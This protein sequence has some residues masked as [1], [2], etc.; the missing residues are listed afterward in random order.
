MKTPYILRTIATKI[1]EA[2]GNAILV[3]G[4][5]RDMLMGGEVKDYDI[6][7]FGLPS[8]ERLLEILSAFGTVNEVGR[9]F[10]ILKLRTGEEEYD[11]SLPRKERKSGSGHRG[12]SVEVDGSMG[13]AEAARR[14][15][16]TVNAIGYDLLTHEIYDPYGGCYDIQY[17]RLRHIDDVSFMEDPLRVYR[18]VQ[19]AARLQFEV[20]EE[21]AGLCRRMVEEGMLAELPKERIYEEF[22]K[23]LLKAS[24]PSVG[25][26]LMRA[27]GITER[28]FPELHALIDVPQ[29]PKWHPE[30]DVWIHTM[31]SID[32][33]AKIVRSAP[34]RR[35]KCPWGKEVGSRSEKEKL[36]LLFAVLCHDFGKPLTTTIE[37][38]QSSTKV[39][40]TNTPHSSPLPLH[41]KVRAIG[42]E[43]AGIDPTRHFLYRLT[44]EHDF[45]ESVVPLVAHH[46]KPSQFHAQGAKAPAIR[47]LARKVNIEELVLVAKADFLGRTTPEAQS[48]RYEAGEW[49]LSEAQRLHVKEKPL[50]PLIG[51]KALIALGLRPSARFK[52][53]LDAV[54]EKQMEGEI[55]SEDEAIAYVKA[56]FVENADGA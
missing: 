45:I 9:S 19:F 53:I 27:W 43:K 7:V 23:L 47:R 41:Y 3:G 38:D 28:Y 2:G 10:G 49:L 26:E 21:T 54:Y 1:A 17:G 39:L 46:L 32:A 4:A 34:D 42:H 15:D 52:E 56:H 5:V 14:R 11:F 30:G 37:T 18:A 20:A 6:E 16:F 25:F 31:M 22:K 24:K 50:D 36:K 29:D 35:D 8:M 12:F 33:M 44:N 40:H 13:F 55:Q 51:G 48:G